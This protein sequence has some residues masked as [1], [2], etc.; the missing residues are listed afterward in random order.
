MVKNFLLVYYFRGGVSLK[1]PKVGNY[2]LPQQADAL[3]DFSESIGSWPQISD[4][5]GGNSPRTTP[6]NVPPLSPDSERGHP[7][8]EFLRQ[9]S[10]VHSPNVIYQSNSG[11]EAPFTGRNYES[12]TQQRSQVPLAVVVDPATDD[13]IEGLGYHANALPAP[14]PP[15]PLSPSAAAA[16]PWKHQNN[17]PQVV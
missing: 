3:H 12:T 5:Q 13:Q 1:S 17:R 15:P 10:G 9:T 4:N 16:Q 8:T 14:P 2:S 7:Q 6:R 11:S